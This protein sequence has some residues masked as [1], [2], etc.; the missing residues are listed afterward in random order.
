MDKFT[1]PSIHI[2]IERWKYHKEL[3]VYVSSKGRI[4]DKNGKIQTVG[5]CSKYLYYKGKRIHRLVA[6]LF[7]PTPNSDMLTIDHKDHNTRNNCVSNLEWVTLEENRRRA[8]AD[9]QENK[10]P[11]GA[12]PNNVDVVKKDDALYVRLNGVKI[13]FKAAKSLVKTDTRLQSKEQ[14]QQI[15]NIFANLTVNKRKKY[16][17]YVI[18]LCEE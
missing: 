11:K 17:G 3:G 7:M 13:P 6:E 1:L 12:N 14:H 16:G 15:E 4:K 2:E 18:Q 9:F 10:P 5:A 8:E